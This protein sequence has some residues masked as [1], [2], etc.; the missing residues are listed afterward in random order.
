MSELRKLALIVV[1]APSIM[2]ARSAGGGHVE[3]G[4]GRSAESSQ[5]PF[6]SRKR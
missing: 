5:A 2:K 6:G 4:Q 3:A 1:G